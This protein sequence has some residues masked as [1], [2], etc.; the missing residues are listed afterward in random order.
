MPQPQR[1]CLRR[2]GNVLP[3]EVRACQSVAQQTGILLDPI[4]TL[5]GW[6]AATKLSLENDCEGQGDDV[7]MLH[8]G[9]SLGLFG[10]AQRYPKEFD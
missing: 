9:G 8:T 1:R 10:L 6:E 5:A 2:F 3:G 7:V 4:Y